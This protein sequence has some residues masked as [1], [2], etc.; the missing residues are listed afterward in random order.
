MV[1]KWRLVESC[2]LVINKEAK[3][4]TF[5]P[6]DVRKASNEGILL[7]EPEFDLK[8]DDTLIPWIKWKEEYYIVKNFI[9]TNEARGKLI[10]AMSGLEGT[11]L[12]PVFS[13]EAG[14]AVW[15]VKAGTPEYREASDEMIRRLNCSMMKKTRKWQVG[16]R[17]DSEDK[18]YYYLGKFVSHRKNYDSS[19][20]LRDP[21]ECHLVV[22]KIPEGIK[23][24][25]D[26]LRTCLYGSTGKEFIH[27]L[28]GNLPLMVDSG[29]ALTNSEEPWDLQSL[30]MDQLKN[31]YE[32]GAP[33]G[34]ALEIFTYTDKPDDVFL[35]TSVD[36]DPIIGQVKI[37]MMNLLIEWWALK[38]NGD[39]QYVGPDQSEE[40]NIKGLI[41]LFSGNLD[42][43]NIFGTL[44]YPELFKLINIDL[45]S[46]AREAII[47]WG[48]GYM[49]KSDFDYYVKVLPL[50]RKH[51]RE[52]VDLDQTV[53]SGSTDNYIGKKFNP[54]LASSLEKLLMSALS[55]GG[56]GVTSWKE[57]N[58]GTASKPDI[59]IQARVLLSDI[60]DF[61]EPSETLKNDIINSGF[62][63]LSIKFMKD[64]GIK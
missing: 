32:T 51:H 26:V 59:V 24:I 12:D 62:Q 50:W 8:F 16:H 36:L 61:A 15:F 58:R 47:N 20:F 11:G 7:S 22:E 46:I 34:K 14:D 53:S 43:E 19:E 45:V 28:W 60:L 44:Y 42:Q 25:P 48:G 56:D 54:D 40:R 38:Y 9:P 5:R 52:V 1:E 49:L 17:Y 13:E 2:R 21:V 37:T 64:K 18:T 57:I 6:T 41:A 63:E 33:L 55:N 3:E 23:T 39:T 10:R 35:S 27:T 29:Q 31:V 30:Y 4:V